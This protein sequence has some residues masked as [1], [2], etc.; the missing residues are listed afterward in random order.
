MPFR[1]AGEVLRG[2]LEEA[3]ARFDDKA[4]VAQDGDILFG[5]RA[6]FLQVRLEIV[7]RIPER[8]SA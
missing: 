4:R 8:A 3:A 2:Q 6:Y 1:F 7:M 5:W